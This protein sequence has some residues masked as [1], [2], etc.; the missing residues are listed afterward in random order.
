MAG[1][2]DLR[3]EF[4]K[5]FLKRLI[6]EDDACGRII[7]YA[8]QPGSELDVQLRGNYVNIY[9]RGGNILRIR[10]R[11]LDFDAFYFYTECRK[12]DLQSRK[13]KLLERSKNGDTDAE[14]EVE[15]LMTKKK[16]F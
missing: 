8:S 10:P 16:N 6:S 4:S 13:T 5:Q 15:V 11:S 1:K 2:Y 12:G 3:G 7:A 9:Y 14:K